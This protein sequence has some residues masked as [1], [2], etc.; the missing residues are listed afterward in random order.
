MYWKKPLIFLLAITC[1]FLTSCTKQEETKEYTVL[2]NLMNGSL[3]DESFSLS[4]KV[5]EGESITLPE[6]TKAGYIFNGWSTK[7]QESMK[8]D[9]FFDSKITSNTILY[10]M[11]RRPTLTFEANEGI[12]T[13]YK[14]VDDVINGFINDFAFFTDYY[15]SA[16]YFFESSYGR[17]Q[18]FLAVHSEW[19]GLMD[20]LHLH[21]SADTAPYFDSFMSE[22]TWDSESAPYIRAEIEAFL[23]KSYFKGAYGFYVT[24]GNYT[25]V[26]IQNDVWSYIP[27][28]YPTF[29]SSFE[30]Y[31][32]P[33][34]K[35]KGY[36]FL[37]WCEQEDLSDE[38]IFFIPKGESTDKTFYAKW[39]EE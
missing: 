16:E 9:F 17:L 14:T 26:E 36:K 19:M 15:I 35:K 25:S 18:S 33:I 6:V 24:S 13:K 37:G 20:Y 10:A 23:T 32:L 2:F 11:W 28:S 30:D 4:L 21:A 12:I 22:D 1:I 7:L 38:A 31:E 27:E 8:A 5:K 34:P 29:Y 3:T 39:K